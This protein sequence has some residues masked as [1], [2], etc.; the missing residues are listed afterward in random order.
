MH[1]N[2]SISCASIW[3]V[4]HASTIVCGNERNKR[5]NLNSISVARQLLGWKVFQKDGIR[6][7]RPS[8]SQTGWVSQKQSWWFQFRP[9]RT[10][11]A[12]R[13]IRCIFKERGGKLCGMTKADFL[14]RAEELHEQRSASDIDHVCSTC[15]KV[16]R[17]WLDKD[18]HEKGIHRN[19]T[20]VQFKCSLCEKSYMSKTSLNYH[21]DV[22]HS[23][24]PVL[25]CQ[26]CKKNLQPWTKSEEA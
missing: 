6:T 4:Q 12:T 9:I 18:R 1:P 11:D 17:N 2:N 15:F 16:F 8:K 22:A 24:K 20:N 19:D 26:M 25:K 5:H 23:V 21:I 14:A 10:S 7:Y 3:K 13:I